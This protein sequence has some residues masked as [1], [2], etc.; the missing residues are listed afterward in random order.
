M[1]IP[2]LLELH[3]KKNSNNKKKKAKAKNVSQ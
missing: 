1:H 3:R 2:E